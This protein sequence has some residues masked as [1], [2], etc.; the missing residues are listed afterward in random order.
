M[1]DLVMLN[2]KRYKNNKL[3]IKE[4]IKVIYG[5]QCVLN[6]RFDLVSLLKYGLN[7]N[8]VICNY[9]NILVGYCP[10]YL[11]TK[12]KNENNKSLESANPN[13]IIKEFEKELKSQMQVYVSL[14]NEEE[15][16][17]IIEKFGHYI[18]NA[19]KIETD[20][21]W[22]CI[23]TTQ[24]FVRNDFQKILLKSIEREKLESIINQF[25]QTYGVLTLLNNNEEWIDII[26]T[27]LLVYIIM[28]L[29]K[30][31]NEEK[32]NEEKIKKLTILFEKLNVP[33]D[34]TI[35]LN[36]VIRTLFKNLKN[37]EGSRLCWCKGIKVVKLKSDSKI[38]REI[39]DIIGFTINY[40]DNLYFENSQYYEFWEAD[41]LVELLEEH[42]EYL[43][44][45]G[46]KEAD[47]YSYEKLENSYKRRL[48]NY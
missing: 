5:E 14:Y 2:R 17:K 15:C 4:G 40:M 13:K 47:K 19:L 23:I 44:S 21:L 8:E 20:E 35:D 33:K 37:A 11:K 18:F 45:L 9:Y 7:S 28:R 24:P 39:G 30:T 16:F 43:K 42:R 48:L 26:Y 38:V 6:E 32:S 1:K 41:Y 10:N 25:I 36:E 29:I 27:S 22:K 46:K 3:E 31:L 12:L 34:N